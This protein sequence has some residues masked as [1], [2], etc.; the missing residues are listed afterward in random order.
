M[1]K[2]LIISSC[3][4]KE[5]SALQLSY[6]IEVVKGSNYEYQIE[7]FPAGTYEIPFVINT[8]QKKNPFDGY[9]ALGLLLNSNREHYNYIMS[10]I[11]TCFT[12]FALND[13][14]VGNGII[15][16]CDLDD[17]SNKV[18]SSNPCV[19]AYTSAFNAVDYLIQLKKRIL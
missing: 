3:I 15:S 2:I 14:I 8:F 4:H 6:C 17:L 10:H 9:I 12:Q 5:L 11:N 13:V 18:N 19:S 16:G 1:A 7:S